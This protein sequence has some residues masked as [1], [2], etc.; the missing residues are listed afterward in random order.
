MIRSIL[1]SGVILLG[2]PGTLF[3]GLAVS[4]STDS[5]LLRALGIILPAFVVMGM[6]V[7]LGRW[8]GSDKAQSTDAVQHD[9]ATDRP[10]P[11]R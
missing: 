11:D 7:G 6:L 3:C 9:D 8:K 5:W 4:R 1:V 2:F 10:T